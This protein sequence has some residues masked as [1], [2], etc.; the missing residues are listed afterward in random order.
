MNDTAA[1]DDGPRTAWIAEENGQ[2]YALRETYSPAELTIWA[3]YVKEFSSPLQ[4][5]NYKEWLRTMRD[6]IVEMGSK[7]Q[8]DTRRHL[9][10]AHWEDMVLLDIPRRYRHHEHLSHI[11]NLNWDLE[12]VKVSS[13]CHS[14]RASKYPCYYTNKDAANDCREC[15]LQGKTCTLGNNERVNKKRPR[16]DSVED[17]DEPTDSKGKQKEHTR[18][19]RKVESEEDNWDSKLIKRLELQLEETDRQVASLSDERNRIKQCYEESTDLIAQLQREASQQKLRVEELEDEVRR[20]HETARKRWEH[21][22][23]VQRRA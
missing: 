2:D 13:P 12:P 10:D 19:K 22:P 3:E 11:K 15:Y 21:A 5:K 8:V 1:S 17:D 6:I 23:F 4:R 16:A 7:Q 20:A 9:G 14:C 18:K